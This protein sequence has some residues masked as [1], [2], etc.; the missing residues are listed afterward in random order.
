MIYLTSRALNSLD[1]PKDT[2]QR[3][4]TLI[5]LNGL[6]LDPENLVTTEPL[7]LHLRLRKFLTS[8]KIDNSDFSLSLI[9]RKPQFVNRM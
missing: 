8:S 3:R 4:Q 1:N 6:F 5:N 9:S 7:L 2:A